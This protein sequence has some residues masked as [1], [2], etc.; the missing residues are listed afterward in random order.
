MLNY[1]GHMKRSTGLA[2]DWFKSVDE[3]TQWLMLRCSV[4]PVRS[5]GNQGCHWRR[6]ACS[7]SHWSW[8]ELPWSSQWLAAEGWLLSC[9]ARHTQ[10]MRQMPLKHIGILV[11]STQALIARQCRCKDIW[12]SYTVFLYSMQKEKQLERSCTVAAE[13]SMCWLF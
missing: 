10:S 6:S 9:M 5:C 12:P 4:C 1:W 11:L 8:L 7:A 3:I 13:C 2:E